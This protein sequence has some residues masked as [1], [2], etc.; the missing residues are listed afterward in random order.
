M[1][2][3]PPINNLPPPA[4]PDWREELAYRH[5][6]RGLVL[7]RRPG[8]AD[9]RELAEL[10][11]ERAA[12]A[13]GWLSQTQA[14]GAPI[15]EA[16]EAAP[17]I[18][19]ALA[20]AAEGAAAGAAALLGFALAE[21]AESADIELEWPDQSVRRLPLGDDVSLGPSSW[22]RAL[23]C[24]LIARDA[25]A[26]DILCD[27][28]YVA[29]LQWPPHLA[30][31]FWPP[32]CAA[33]AA[34]VWGAP[35]ADLLAEAEALLAPEQVLCA[36]PAVTAAQ[37]APLVPL[38]R[39]LSERGAFAAALQTALEAHRAYYERADA[40]NSAYRGAPLEV[41]GWA[42]LAH[43]RG[44]AFDAGELPVA[45][46]QGTARPSLLSVT[47]AYRLRRAQRAAD[48]TGFLDLRGFPRAGRQQAV[49]SRAGGLV[50]HYTLTGRAGIPHATAEFL[51]SD[52]SSGQLP[53]PALDDGERM[54]LAEL[55]AREAGGALADG[56]TQGARSWLAAAV[57]TVDAVLAALP[58]GADE[59]PAAAFV[60]P[61]GRAAYEAEPGRFRRARLAAYRASL[62]Q[63]LQKLDDQAAL[64]RAP[65]DSAAAANELEA[66]TTA[67]AAIETIRAQ[68]T[69]L[70][71]AFGR[72]RTGELVAGLKPRD[73]DYAKVF[74][75]EAVAAARAAYQSFWQTRPAITV[76]PPR[77]SALLC[78]VAPA[79]LLATEHELAR[80][81][82]GG[83]RAL[84]RWLNPQ[85]VWVAWKYVEP[86]Q[87]SG[88]A[89]DG[90]VWCDDHWAWFPK[91]YRALGTLLG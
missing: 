13:A 61:L 31:R 42:A 17:L 60:N 10:A 28:E 9:A 87:T 25:A 21:A 27:P 78:Y 15:A 91:P 53:A 74:R 66:K 46:V 51:L 3:S 73:E 64:E 85:R 82:P 43:Q 81:F 69:P 34:V 23:A 39:A 55:Y 38:L 76:P 62:A 7:A 1:D 12:L 22:F 33:A 11:F 2:P 6:L 59:L 47:F 36:D 83:Y 75:A 52:D 67:Y 19:E 20:A 89:F 88:L 54:L 32:L 45:L 86:G 56:D 48:A 4:P 57:E 18:A 14:A 70:L 44:L 90:L 84:A 77:Q 5:K 41:L 50:A 35:S 79:G 29:A 63:Q 80:H 26:L 40:P 24:A 72:D 68:V 71:E 8:R 58:T 37:L 65:A 30:D 49:L 16:A